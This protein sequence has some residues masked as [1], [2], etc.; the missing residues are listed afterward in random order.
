MGIKFIV[1]D[2]SLEVGNAKIDSQHQGILGV[3]NELYDSA[4][5]GV[6][7]DISVLVK[8]LVDYSIHH[9]MDEEELMESIGY[10][11]IERHRVLHNSLRR[12][13]LKIKNDDVSSSSEKQLELLRFLKD[14]WLTHIANEDHKYAP[15]LKSSI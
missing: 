4:V 13:T 9:L 5:S 10:P 3:I 7:M 14:W 2:K 11:D 15:Y 8:N 12:E 1:W 6:T